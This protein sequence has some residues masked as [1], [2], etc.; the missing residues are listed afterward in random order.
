MTRKRNK[1]VEKSETL[2]DISVNCMSLV[3]HLYVGIGRQ[4]RKKNIEDPNKVTTLSLEK[5][6]PYKNNHDCFLVTCIELD[7]QSIFGLAS[8]PECW[9]VGGESMYNPNA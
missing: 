2:K 4:G 6:L 3:N 1:K 9:V 5:S 8:S 7:Q